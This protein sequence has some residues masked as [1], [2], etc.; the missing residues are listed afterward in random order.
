MQESWVRIF[1]FALLQ[2]GRGEK[3][4][5]AMLFASADSEVQISWLFE[6]DI[7]MFYKLF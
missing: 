3:S 7:G 1:Y 4:A 2:A 6:N 5:E